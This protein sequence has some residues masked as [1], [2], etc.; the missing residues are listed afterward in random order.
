[1]FRTIRMVCKHAITLPTTRMVATPLSSDTGALNA[2]SASMSQGQPLIR[3]LLERRPWVGL[4]AGRRRQP[5]ATPWSPDLLSSSRNGYGAARFRS[6][7][8]PS[9]LFTAWRLNCR[10][11]PSGRRRGSTG[12]CYCPGLPW[13]GPLQLGCAI[14]VIQLGEEASLARKELRTVLPSMHRP[15]ISRPIRSKKEF[16]SNLPKSSSC[17]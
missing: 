16:R 8:L 17:R 6:A 2:S 7:A 1:M 11:H 3:H 13:H 4:A 9:A 10:R 12:H 15:S 5:K 14:S